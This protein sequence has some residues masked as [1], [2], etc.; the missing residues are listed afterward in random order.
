MTGFTVGGAG[1]VSGLGEVAGVDVVAAVVTCGAAVGTLLG[2]VG[3]AQLG[4]QLRRALPGP[5]GPG[6]GDLGAHP[7]AEGDGS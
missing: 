7:A 3:T 6:P 1:V 4:I 5:G 2:L